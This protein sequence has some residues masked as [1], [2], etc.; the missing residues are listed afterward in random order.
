MKKTKT[1]NKPKKLKGLKKVLFIGCGVLLAL[2]V[3]IILVGIFVP[4]KPSVQIKSIKNGA[5]TTDENLELK[6]KFA[7]VNSVKV[8]NEDASINQGRRE[9]TKL[10]KLIPGENVVKV[11]GFKDGQSQ[12]VQEIKINFDLEGRLYQ[13]KL[14]AERKAD[15]EELKERAKTPIYEV[16]RKENNDNGFSAVIYID[17]G[18]LK[19]YYVCNT[20]KD[21]RNKDENKK[22]KTISLLIF[23]KKDKSDVESS[24]EKNSDKTALQT[25]S[26]K[27][28][29]DYEKND[30]DESLFYFPNGFQNEKLALEV[31]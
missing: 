15:E 12:A 17:E 14:E 16:V 2:F 7:V 10:I 1:M 9:F 26:D 24:F 27:G 3:I 18:E 25:I 31:K 6:G 22:V 8:N 20:I 30:K 11:E 21:F 19:D 5:D 28:R 13:E 29:G 4:E 23:A